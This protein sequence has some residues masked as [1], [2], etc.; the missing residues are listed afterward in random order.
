[1]NKKDIMNCLYTLK[2]YVCVDQIMVVKEKNP[3]FKIQWSV[4]KRGGR[5]R[6]LSFRS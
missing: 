3:E 1:M 4:S 5:V 6:W 2:N